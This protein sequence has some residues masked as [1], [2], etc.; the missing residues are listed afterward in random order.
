MPPREV[1]EAR[2]KIHDLVDDSNPVESPTAYYAFFHPADRSTLFTYQNE[3]G[4]TQG[5]VGR[6]QTGAD[7]FRPLVTLKCTRASIAAD[8]LA[9]ALIVGRPYILFAN[10]NQLPLVGGSL[11]VENERILR[12]YTADPARFK[13]VMNVMVET[14]IT[15]DGLPRCVINAN[16]APMAVAGVN[17]KSP[18]FAEIYVHT[19]PQARQRGWGRAVVS[20]LTEKLLKDGIRPVYLVENGN[21]PSRELI[22]GLGYFDTGSR[23]VYADTVYLG[24]PGSKE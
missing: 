13:S 10:L 23:H 14:K 12:I 17:W 9:K 16:N 2:R 18:G 19:E 1:V 4:Q 21:E 8:L 6:F 11:R 3:A 22:E 5:F 15:P 24:H 7:L 20:A